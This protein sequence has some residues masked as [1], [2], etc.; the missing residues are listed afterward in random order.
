M[1]R[2][3]GDRDRLFAFLERLTKRALDRHP[4]I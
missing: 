4:V 1:L 2:L 3:I